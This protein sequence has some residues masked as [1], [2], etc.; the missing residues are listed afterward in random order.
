[1]KRVMMVVV[2]ALVMLSLPVLAQPGRPGGILKAAMQTNPPTLDP[3]LSTNVVVRQVAPYVFETLVVYGEEYD[4]IPQLA[5]SWEISSD[6]LVYIFYLRAGVRFHNGKTL[7]AD[8]VVASLERYFAY[9]PGG[10]RFAGI[11]E[12]VTALNPLTVEIRVKEPTLLLVT[13]AIPDPFLAIYPAEIIRGRQAEVR[14]SDLIGT[15]PYRFA[16][17]RPDVHVR[18]VR[19]AEYTADERF[20]GPSG[21]G[22]RRTAYFEEIQFIPVLEQ[23][24][25]LAGLLTGEFDYAESLPITAYEQLLRNP[26]VVPNVLKPRW[27]LVLELN[28]SEPP[29]DNVLFRRALIAALG[30]EDVLRAV[31]FG[32]PAFYRTQPGFFFPEQ[33]VWHTD[34]GAEGYNKKDLAEVR[35]LLAEAG[36]NFE[37]IIFLSNRDYDW[38]YKCTLAVAS[39]LQ[40]AGINVIVEF[41]DWPSQIQRALTQ[42][43][44]H[45]N[46]TG[47]SPRLDP[48][49]L[50]TSLKCGAPYAYMYCNPEVDRLLSELSRDR[51]VEERQRIF[52]ELQRYM[53]EDVAVL[54]IGDFFTLEGTNARLRGYT[55]WYVIPRF[56]DCWKE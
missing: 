56:W 3:H 11:V 6:G 5:E 13:L 28:Q 1:M 32:N 48:I 43:G 17:W 30:M 2:L 15:G 22:G 38:M 25:R 42:K 20:S 53:W 54:R 18:L 50:A 9:S 10:G 46:Q 4:I 8:D 51:P 26:D 19:F 39:Q 14:G 47:W 33:A 29:M 12:S 31:T 7:T 52:H 37:P 45:I 49:Q 27:A 35:R 16:E 44:W 40:Q 21:L 23:A 24:A 41:S 34:A 36:Y 55:P